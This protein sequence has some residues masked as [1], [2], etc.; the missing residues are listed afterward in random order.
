MANAE[1]K[2]PAT[3]LARWRGPGATGVLD[4]L[5]EVKLVFEADSAGAR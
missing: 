5:R 3:D 1:R 4:L 2:A